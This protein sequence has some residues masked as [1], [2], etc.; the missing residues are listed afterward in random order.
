MSGSCRAF[1][2]TIVIASAAALCAGNGARAGDKLF[3]YNFSDYFAEDTVSNFSKRTGIDARVDFFDSLEVLETRLL[4][5]GS[6][7]DVTFPSATVG[8]RLVQSG[9]LKPIDVSALKNYQNL[10]TSLLKLVAEHDPGNQY[11]VPYMWLTTG[12][13]YNPKLV[14]ERVGGAPTNSLDMFFKPE[15]ARKFQDC[16]IGIVDAPNEV[17]PIA[18]N[19][20]GLDPYSTIQGDLEKAKGL[21]LTLRPYIR[22]MQSGQLVADM[23]SGQLCLAMM[24]SGDAGIAAA[25][26][27]EAKNGIAVNYSIPKEGTIISFDTM[28][29]PGDAPDPEE[30]LAFIDY[31]L[32]PKTVADIS[33]HVFYANANA[34]AT[35]LVDEAIRTDPNVYPPED[36][37]AKLFVDKSLPPRQA[38]ERTR[39]WTAFRAGN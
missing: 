26:A 21:L 28:A 23:A 3:I 11:L 17:I 34:A 19:Y 12:I 20:L 25:R 18:L 6:G 1:L 38:R 37:R 39:V 9:A 7:F 10:D 24:W 32:E 4:A 8:E 31:V 14:E 36:V 35:A 16:G 2:H 30:A 27:E 13:A 22:H 15:L 33:N 5:G 29:I